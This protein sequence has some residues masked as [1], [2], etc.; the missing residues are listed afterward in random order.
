MYACDDSGDK[1]YLIPW[2]SWSRLDLLHQLE[3]EYSVYKRQL[4]R[5]LHLARWLLGVNKVL[6]TH[7]NGILLLEGGLLTSKATGS[8][9]AKG[10]W[11]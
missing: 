2:K 1:E 6:R 5:F 3:L 11:Y 7:T 9:F 10:K 8:T 4:T